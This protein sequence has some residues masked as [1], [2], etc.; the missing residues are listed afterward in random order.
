MPTNPSAT[1][2][3]QWPLTISRPST[4]PMKLRSVARSRSWCASTTTS[5]PFSG[6]APMFS[7]P[8]RGL[9]MP[10][11]SCAYT[12]PSSANCTSW[13]GLVSTLAPTSSARHRPVAVGMRAPTGGRSTPA[14]VRRKT[15]EAAITAPVLPAL[16][17]AS[18][19]PA[20]S[21][22]TPT[23]MDESRLRRTAVAGASPISITSLA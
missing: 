5:F 7:S 2:T 13:W 12:L 4:L 21:R 22:F 23:T 14:M 3:S 9:S 6:S 17:K 15:S 8:T 19:S 1:S 20:L 18:T 10:R 11:M 16:M